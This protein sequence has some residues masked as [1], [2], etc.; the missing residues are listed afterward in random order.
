ME[1]FKIAQYQK[2]IY[3]ITEKINFIIYVSALKNK[4]IDL[5]LLKN[6][7]DYKFTLIS[8]KNI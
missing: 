6:A 5:S 2:S 3:N 7:T 1:S 8:E 4:S